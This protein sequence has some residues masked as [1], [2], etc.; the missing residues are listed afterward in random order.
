MERPIL[1]RIDVTI[2][3]MANGLF[4]FLTNIRYHLSLIINI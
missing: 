3:C 4:S 1:H 2:S